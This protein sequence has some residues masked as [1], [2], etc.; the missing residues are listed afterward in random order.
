MS[1][2]ESSPINERSNT[3]RK[4]V[5]AFG[6][7]GI[8]V[9]TY[10]TY[11]HYSGT[12][13]SCLVSGGCEAVQTSQWSKFLGIPVALIGLG[14]YIG[15]IASLLVQGE[16]GRLLTCLLCWVGLAFS[17][18]LTYHE[19]FSVQRICQWCVGSQII[20]LLLAGLSSWRLVSDRYH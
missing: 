6:L 13:T 18:Y 12:P 4:A 10:L 19:L 8:C 5:F 11:H 20:I 9:A 7:L 3:L 15:I 1:I 2:Q 16:N 14:G 17:L